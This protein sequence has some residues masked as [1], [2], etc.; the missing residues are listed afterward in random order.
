MAIVHDAR[1]HRCSRKI[2]IN[3]ARYHTTAAPLVH[4]FAAMARGR[5]T[6]ARFANYLAAA[7]LIAGVTT[8]AR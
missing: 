6:N 8:V 3:H 5:S 7:M 2:E 1:K 4:K